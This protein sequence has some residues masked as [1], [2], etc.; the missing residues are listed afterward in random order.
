MELCEQASREQDPK[1]LMALTAE[2]IR[3]LD[4]KKKR[5]TGSQPPGPQP[6]DPTI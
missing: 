5:V 1:K 2:I 3:L 4:E 6:L